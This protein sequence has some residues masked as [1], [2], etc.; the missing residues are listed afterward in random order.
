M[1]MRRALLLIAMLAGCGQATAPDDAI[2]IGLLLSYSGS[3]AANSTNSERAVRM[4][5]ETANASG[6]LWGRQL[7]LIPRDTR[8]DPSKVSIAARELMDRHSALIIGPDTSDTA[9]QLR[10]MLDDETIIMPSFTTAHANFRRPVWWFVMG[11]G[12]A[13]VAC[14]LHAQ[15]VKDGHVKPIILADS[16]NYG[17]LVAWEMTRRYSYPQ[18]LL[19]QD[20]SS[21]TSTIQPIIDAD[22]DSY[23]LAAQPQSASS[24]IYAM[25]AI[26]QL[27]DPTRWYLS[28]TLHTPALLATIPGGVLDGAQGVAP[29]QVAGAN[30]FRKA[31]RARWQEAP[32]DD[33]YSFYDAA[34]IAV[35]AL[36]RSM[37]RAGELATGSRLGTHV[38]A[39]THGS[40]N[41]IGWDEI[42]KGLRLLN[43]GQEIE[44]FGLTGLIEFDLT[45]QTPT[46]NMRWWT[47]VPDGF[48]DNISHPSGCKATL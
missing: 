20:Q 8:S 43:E 1:A 42:A 19:P 37:A 45:G 30:D 28:P 10:G 29:G 6:G 13:R 17:A 11:A 2:P 5:I 40:A 3:L 25:A 34:A 26:G 35:L 46:A 12:T 32:Q 48:D 7:E 15:L 24:L 9:V 16:S 33:A 38:A 27:K 23:V 22:A 18:V 4:A 41:R 36:G 14:E 31:F 44:Y 21:N 47:V 39:V